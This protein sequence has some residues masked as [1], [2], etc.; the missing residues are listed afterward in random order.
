MAPALQ[1][2]CQAVFPGESHEPVPARVTRGTHSCVR[3]GTA[4]ITTSG[5]RGVLTTGLVLLTL[6]MHGTAAEPGAKRV[7]F[8]SRHLPARLPSPSVD[9]MRNACSDDLLQA[10]SL[11]ESQILQRCYSLSGLTNAGLQP[12]ARVL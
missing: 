5:V 12:P 6:G 3:P 7:S 11:S 4:A 2:L 8:L 1:A 10:A 9:R